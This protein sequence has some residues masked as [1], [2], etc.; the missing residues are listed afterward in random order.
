MCEAP[1]GWSTYYPKDVLFPGTFYLVNVDDK[2]RRQY[3]I[4]EGPIVPPKGTFA[5]AAVTRMLA[6]RAAKKKAEETGAA[7]LPAPARS[8]PL[9]VTGVAVGLPGH[10]DP[11]CAG[12]LDELL[13]GTNMISPIHGGLRARLLEKNVHQMKKVARGEAVKVPIDSEEKS[14]K[15]AAQLAPIDLGR[16]GV[17]TSLAGTLDTAASIAVGAGLLALKDAG[18][19]V[20]RDGQKASWVVAPELQASTGVIYITSFPGLDATVDEVMRFLQVSWRV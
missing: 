7:P 18:L 16:F 17:S 5:P 4:K 11:F 12:G 8:P 13:A 14:L 3:K 15:L 9:P 2:Y 6:E 20:G 19:C 1:A 10:D